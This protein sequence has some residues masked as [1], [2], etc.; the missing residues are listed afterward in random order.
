LLVRKKKVIRPAREKHY[1]IARL[2]YAL[3]LGLFFFFRLLPFRVAFHTGEV[4]GWLLYLFDR[5][6]R[7]TGLRNLALAFP[8]KSAAEHRQIL[9]ASLLNF[10][11]LIAEFCHLHRLTPENISARVQFAD[12][13]QWQQLIAQVQHTGAL[14][15]TGHFGNWELL[16]YAHACYGFP[17][18]IIHRRLRNALID[19]FITRER[20]RCGT[21][22]IKKTTAGVEVFRA[23]R[24][25]RIIVVAVDQNA[26]GRMGVFVPF[27]SRLAST[28]TGLAGLALASGVPVIPVFLVRE[29]GS[30]RH[31]IILLPSVAPIR[32]GDQAADLQATTAKFTAVFQHM[33]EQYPDHW[34][35]VHKRWKRRP[36]GEAPIY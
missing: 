23:M 2:E 36:D 34:L 35:W 16:G 29:N 19:D 9:R 8:H 5:G 17:G 32:T 24:N 33:V 13:L 14:I 7:R 28:S 18:H 4:V 10:G 11:R 26:S 31:H 27:F 21:K 1:V 15:L 3:F 6:H 25:K 22:I 20:E 30:W 12:F